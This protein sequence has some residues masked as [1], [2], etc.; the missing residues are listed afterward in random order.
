[1]DSGN[2]PAGQRR[3]LTR[4]LAELAT[5]AYKLGLLRTIT[6]DR[7]GT[8]RGSSIGKVLSSELANRRGQSTWNERRSGIFLLR[9]SRR[10]YPP[11]YIR[12]DN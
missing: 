10:Y 8:I 2:L 3:S 4:Y 7:S 9:S 1:M 6:F 5:T 11:L 12:E